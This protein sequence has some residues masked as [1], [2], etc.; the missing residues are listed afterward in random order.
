[1]SGP[2]VRKYG[3]PNHESIFGKK[4]IEHG[5]DEGHA[6]VEPSTEPARS[7][8]K[9]A[10]KGREQEG[11]AQEEGLGKS[12][13]TAGRSGGRTGSGFSQISVKEALRWMEVEDPWAGS[14]DGGCPGA[15][16]WDDL[17]R[18]VKS[19]G[20]LRQRDRGRAELPDRQAQGH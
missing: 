8:K 1:M 10:Q 16:S 9:A 12:Q 18:L 4:E 7:E 11:L 20:V 13:S 2:I 3:F 6:E 17:A 15:S 14:G 5:V 19:D